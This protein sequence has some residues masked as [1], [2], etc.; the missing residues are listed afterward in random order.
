MHE[1]NNNSLHIWHARCANAR[2][3]QRSLLRDQRRRGR[4]RVWEGLCQPGRHLNGYHRL[5]LPH[6]ACGRDQSEHVGR[7]LVGEQ[8][9]HLDE[10]TWTWVL[11][12]QSTGAGAWAVW[13]RIIGMIRTDFWW[14]I[15]IPRDNLQY[16]VVASCLRSYSVG[17]SANQGI[18]YATVCVFGLLVML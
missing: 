11:G 6:V 4:N 12:S 18:R 16:C 9:G 3:H 2:A 1:R 17:S 14:R 5:H 7:V 13:C 10:Q 8:G 15:Y